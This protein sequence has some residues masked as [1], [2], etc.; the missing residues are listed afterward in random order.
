MMENGNLSPLGINS[1]TKLLF[2]WHTCSITVLS[3]ETPGVDSSGNIVMLSLIQ[4]APD[5]VHNLP[6]CRFQPPSTA[7]VQGHL[8]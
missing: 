7:S 2:R 5:R 6:V 1:I 4:R 3:R 8:S